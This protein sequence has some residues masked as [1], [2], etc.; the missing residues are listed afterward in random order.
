MYNRYETPRQKDFE[1]FHFLP[2]SRQYKPA[3]GPR[4]DPAFVVDGRAVV[5]QWGMIESGSPVRSQKA[6]NNARWET[7][8]RLPTFR[9]SWAVDHLCLIPA[10]SFDE[11]RWGTGKTSGGAFDEAT[12]RRGQSQACGRNGL[13]PS[14]VR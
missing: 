6:T 8:R 5:G 13:I 1:E 10:R 4:Q 7:V 11:P 14:P 3:I 2:P 9:D 12:L